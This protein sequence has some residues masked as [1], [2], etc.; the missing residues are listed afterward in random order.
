[1]LIKTGRLSDRVQD[2]AA[3]RRVGFN[4]QRQPRSTGVHQPR[5]KCVL[6][7]FM[8]ASND[9]ACV[10]ELFHRTDRSHRLGGDGKTLEFVVLRAT[11]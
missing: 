7:A 3:I 8:S 10:H 9:E 5:S 4:D 1:L 2:H 11:E 6:L